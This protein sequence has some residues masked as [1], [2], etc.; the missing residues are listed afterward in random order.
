M[1]PRY[2][3]SRVKGRVGGWRKGDNKVPLRE[4]SIYEDHHSGLP[5][6]VAQTQ[7]CG[8]E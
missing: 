7:R 6:K 5:G 1:G 8:V 3:R 4:E 2:V